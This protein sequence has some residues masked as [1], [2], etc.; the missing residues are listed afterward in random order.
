MLVDRTYNFHFDGINDKKYQILLKKAENLR[1]FRN[2]ISQKIC[3]NPLLYMNLKKYE[4]VN[5]FRKDIEFCNNQDVS[6]TIVEVYKSYDNKRTQVKNSTTVKIQ[7][8][9]KITV[10]K[11]NGKNFKK[12]QTKSFNV[13]LKSTKLT[14]VVSYLSRYYNEGLLEF[15]KT[16]VPKNEKIREFRSMV[17]SYVDKFGDRLLDLAKNKQTRII[18][19]V[20]KHPIEFT[21]L[22]FVSCTE[23]KQNIITRNP[24]T[25]SIYNAYITL[26]GQPVSGGK[27]SIPTKFSNDF[28]GKIKH[29]YKQPNKKGQRNT[30]Y[31]IIFSGKDDVKIALTRKKKDETVVGKTS[32]Y[33]IDVN[34][35]H[36]LFCDKYNNTIDFDRDIFNDYIKFLKIWDAKLSVKK[37]KNNGNNEGVKLSKK[38]ELV[39]E[40]WIGR[41]RD[42]LE[43][44]ANLLVKRA[45]A[46]GKDHIVME[47]LG[48]MAKSFL[49]SQDLQGFKYSRL[50][51]LLNLTDL[52]NITLS[53]AN[54]NGLQVTFVQPHYSSK[55]CKCGNIDD[56]NR[57]I[58]EIFKCIACGLVRPAVAHSADILED[59]LRIDVLRSKLLTCENG[60]YK[61]KK[62]SK[63]FIK[64]TLIECYDI[65]VQKI[66]CA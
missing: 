50:I 32:F 56:R 44:K 58:Q 43:R 53:I 4:W 31:T 11:R 24:N 18:D 65:N 2:E 12:G 16:D 28:H 55:G 59:R 6:H 66:L 30:T 57:V 63:S 38:D 7:D 62:V 9:I 23:Q 10:Y 42:M 64:Q 36:N 48:Q 51:R 20:F 34:V 40:K 21:S 22:S 41:I 1:D 29:Y 27:I 5:I 61:P 3:K 60:V 33:G 13:E 26:P 35:K 8:R 37:A 15:I 17:M 54:K 45:I 47:D 49:K 39:K 46:L 14:S 52:K 19:S 25:Q